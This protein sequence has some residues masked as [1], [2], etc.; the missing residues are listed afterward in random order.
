MKLVYVI[1]Y[2]IYTNSTGIYAGIGKKIKNQIVCMQ[3]NGITVTQLNLPLSINNSK[4]FIISVINAYRKL[5]TCIISEEYDIIYCRHFYPYII[6][7]LLISK[8]RSTKIVFEA[9]DIQSKSANISVNLTLLKNIQNLYLKCMDLFLGKYISS[10]ADGIVSVTHEISEY[11]KK[12]TNET[13][14]Y[15]TLG[16]GITTSSE[17]IR[18]PPYIDSELHI[19]CV[20]N[21]HYWHG[22]DRFLNGLKNYNG[23]KQ[24]YF[25]IVGEG[26]EYPHLKSLVQDFNLESHVIFHGFKSGADLDAM[27]DQCHIALGSL[28]G[29][30]INMHEMSSLKSA[31]YCARGIPFVIAAVAVDFPNEWDYILHVPETEEPIDIESVVAFADNVCSDPNHVK[32]M[33]EYAESHLDWLPK[34]RILK[35]FL[36]GL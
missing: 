17:N 24:I 30:R 4:S 32:I 26:H 31:E 5:N 25:H 14:A 34:M 20:A 2:A 36:E 13:L 29:F 6:Y 18:N 33:R 12:R 16:N 1:P 11:H 7:T 21:L 8:G 28:G 3:E 9:Q 27:F 23:P 22:I 10:N 35:E 15:L 19:L